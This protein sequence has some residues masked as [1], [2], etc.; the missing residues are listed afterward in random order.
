[1]ILKINRFFNRVWPRASAVAEI[2]WSGSDDNGRYS[3]YARQPFDV[4]CRLEEH[5]CRM[6]QR[7]VNAQPA[8]GPGFCVVDN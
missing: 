8:N 1:M 2:L 7:G 3:F 6:N 5:V 4:S